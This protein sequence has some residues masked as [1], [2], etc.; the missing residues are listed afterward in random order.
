L[1]L[2]ALSSQCVGET[3]RGED[4]ESFIGVEK[5]KEFKALFSLWIHKIYRASRLCC[6]FLQSFLIF[7]TAQSE[8]SLFSIEQ[9]P[10]DDGDPE[11]T[12]TGAG[13]E[14]TPSSA[15]DTTTSLQPTT[16][17]PT[18][19][20]SAAAQPAA[21]PEIGSAVTRPATVQQAVS[22]E[23]E[24]TITQP[25]AAQPVISPGFEFNVDSLILP[26]VFGHT[27][28]RNEG[29][30]LSTHTSPDPDP[31]IALGELPLGAEEAAWMKP[32]KTL[33]Y[34]R[35]VHRPGKLSDLIVHWYQL[36]EALG[37]PESVSFP[38]T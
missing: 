17:Q 5:A 26:D 34:F 12:I 27:S 11:D 35:E 18:I 24:F 31:L 4:F 21:S 32:K 15:M 37:F 22:P 9:L 20:Q 13:S 28:P 29:Q 19:T 10:E 1:T 14:E 7:H 2:T 30:V 6:V 23:I 3:A 8:W 25:A 33:K 36:E 16:A 38:I